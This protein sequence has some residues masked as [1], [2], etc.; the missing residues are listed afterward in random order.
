MSDTF[1]PNDIELAGNLADPATLRSIMRFVT[2]LGGSGAEFT[3]PGVSS[4]IA[5]ARRMPDKPPHKRRR[6]SRLHP[7]VEHENRLDNYKE[8]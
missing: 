1:E 6:I 2:A 4:S 8:F 3:L 7:C 5:Y